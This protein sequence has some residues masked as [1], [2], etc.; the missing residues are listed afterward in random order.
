MRPFLFPFA[1]LVLAATAVRAQDDPKKKAAELVAEAR[2]LAK[3]KNPDWRKCEELGQKAVAI[4][5]ENVTANDFLAWLYWEKLGD[6]ERA[7]KHL[8]VAI[9]ALVEPKSNGEKQFKAYLLARKGTL[10]YSFKDDL[11]GAR[12]LYKASL[13]TFALSSTADTL[14]NL[15]HRLA[16][17]SKDPKK[18]QEQAKAALDYAQQ[19]LELAPYMSQA[20]S[21][22]AAQ[23]KWLAK[24]KVQLALC[25]EA[26]GDKEGAKKTLEAVDPEDLG[27]S[28]LYNQ[29]LLDAFHG[30]EKAARE[31]LAGSLKLR[32]E[33]R[34]RNQLRKF[35]RTEP[36]FQKFVS[37][38][39]WKELTQDEPE[40]K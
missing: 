21:D 25:K 11:E 18:K 22:P 36:D 8:D 10:I 4:D 6:G 33:P 9:R 20:K 31:K 15:L 39:S 29:A 34:S 7:A 14:S 37:L 32:P 40:A 12:D 30:D 27:D 16:G 17:L 1:L 5:A 35:I 3:D 24:V 28:S 23:K 26:L 2:K 13:D 19:A 38:E